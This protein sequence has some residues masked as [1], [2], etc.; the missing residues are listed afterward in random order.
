MGY[1]ICYLAYHSHTWHGMVYG[2]SHMLH[3]YY[4]NYIQDPL[5]KP[6]VD[7]W[8]TPRT[9]YGNTAIWQIVMTQHLCEVLKTCSGTYI[10]NITRQGLWH[11]LYVIWYITMHD[12]VQCMC[13]S[14][15]FITISMKLF[16][17]KHL[18]FFKIRLSSYAHKH[19]NKKSFKQNLCIGQQQVPTT[20][21]T[22]IKI[23]TSSP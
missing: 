15:F 23:Q 16:L 20:Q 13:D 17:G 7:S 8:F 12:M 18:A 6:S 14:N 19:T 2:I 1:L 21:Y 3:I 22:E 10:K 5:S 9:R 11:N 4:I